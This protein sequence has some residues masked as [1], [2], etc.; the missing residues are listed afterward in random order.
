VNTVVKGGVVMG[1]LC[2][3]WMFV[4]GLTGWYKD[5]Q[6]VYA[7]FLVIVLE[8]GALA[9]VLRQTALEGRGYG[10]QVRAGV[11][12]SGIGAV[13]VF[14]GSLLFTTVAFPGYFEETRAVAEQMMRSRG[15]EEAEITRSLDEMRV[16]GTPLNQAVQGFLGTSVTGLLASL[17]LAAILRSKA[18]PSTAARS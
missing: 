1:A 8:I 14:L 18:A 13:V 7:F 12:V 3:G 15:L 10:A 11:L 2:V 6:M 5:P 9:W 17:G 4:M 16:A